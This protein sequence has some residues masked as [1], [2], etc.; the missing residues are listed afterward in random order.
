MTIEELEIKF[1]AETAGLKEQLGGINKQL[2]GLEAGAEKTQNSFG[3]AFKKIG[4]ILA[5][6]AVGQKLFAIGQEALAMA[7]E[8]V[9]SESLFEVSMEGMAA[10]A[11]AWSEDL[12]K[13]L[14]LN[15]VEVRKSVGI[16]NT[17]FGS[18]GLSEQAAFDMSKS[19]TLLAQD[20]AS[21]YNLDPTEAFQKLQAGIT[22]EA[23]PLKRLGILIDEN[24]I[25]QY[26]MANGISATG[27]NMTQQQKVMARYGAI[28]EQTSK[29]QG[30]LAR[31]LDSPVN[32]LRVLKARADEAKIALGTALQPAL[33]AVLPVLT[34][35]ANGAANLA[36]NLAGLNTDNVLGNVVISLDEARE[37][38]GKSL[39][40]TIQDTAKQIKD[41]QTTTNSKLASYAEAESVM[42]KISVNISINPPTTTGEERIY[43]AVDGIKNRV[44]GYSATIRK[45]VVGNLDA[46]L[47]AGVITQEQYDKE[48]AKLDKQLEKLNKAAETLE[49]FVT[50]KVNAALEDGVVTEKEAGALEKAV[51]L[52]AEALIKAIKAEEL[53]QIKAVDAQIKAGKITEAEGASMK[54]DIREAALLAIGEVNVGLIA[55]QA[56]MG[57]LNWTDRTLTPAETQAVV[58]GI[59]AS[60]RAGNELIVAAEATLNATFNNTGVVGEV[61]TSVFNQANEKAQAAADNLSN[62]MTSWLDGAGITAEDWEKARKYREEFAELVEFMTNG[63]T[64]KGKMNKAMHDL[65]LDP[66]SIGNFSQV[67]GDAINAQI[68]GS[69]ITLDAQL[70]Y[71]FS[72]EDDVRPKLAEQGITFEQAVNDL[73]QQAADALAVKTGDTVMQAAAALMPSIIAA[74]DSGDKST[75]EAGANAILKMFEGVDWSKVSLEGQQAALGLYEQFETAMREQGWSAPWSEAAD[76]LK[77]SV[78]AAGTGGIFGEFAEAAMLELYQ[79]FQNKN[80]TKEEFDKIYGAASSKE[81]LAALAAEAQASG[82]YAMLVYIDALLGY[83]DKAK[84][85]GTTIADSVNKG[86]ESDGSGEGSNLANTFISAVSSKTGEAYEAGK[87][88]GD[89]AKRGMRFSLSIDS[90]SKVAEEIGNFFGEG[91]VIGIDDKAMEATKAAASMAAGAAGA[92]NSIPE[93]SLPF[94]LGSLPEG[95]SVA[96]AVSR[97]LANVNFE[98][99]VDGERLGRIS[100]KAING[101]MA[102]SGRTLLNLG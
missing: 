56:E 67:F 47:K 52:K 91:F 62:L 30:D 2:G 58:N 98:M 31:T 68:E 64:T 44:L 46:Q 51:T 96:Q 5:G 38:I 11:R 53:R 72:F 26:A 35:L 39:D 36:K 71:M 43:T 82:N 81:A 34:N 14:G 3:G 24:T 29:A 60:I 7:N 10:S 41:L 4:G 28:M 99:N 79:G 17:M 63:I 49:T 61:V 78:M 8:A 57:T 6:A 97:A 70:N 12:S 15:A 18:M 65:T 19:M 77:A 84:E 102:K 83:Q 48:V 75:M 40:T 25:S 94:G 37:I 86:L 90:P 59:E 93:S 95:D 92:L 21:F 42:K 74:I 16:L 50:R 55:I 22:G 33:I 101:V 32:Q 73:K 100:I 69:E 23:E 20:M 87:S 66:E 85:A 27:K 13:S 80:I 89:A 9:E 45:T 88:L 1:R 54:Q 76:N